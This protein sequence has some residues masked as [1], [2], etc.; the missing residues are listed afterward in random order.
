M[1]SERAPVDEQLAAQATRPRALEVMLLATVLI[2]RDCLAKYTRPVLSRAGRKA[3]EYLE[4]TRPS[5]PPSAEDC[6]I[7]YAHLADRA[8]QPIALLIDDATK[9]SVGELSFL[10]R[11]TLFRLVGAVPAR[12]TPRSEFHLQLTGDTAA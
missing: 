7:H 4:V 1:D 2:D 9:L 10:S 11:D 3:L 5:V 12:K 6:C 8:L